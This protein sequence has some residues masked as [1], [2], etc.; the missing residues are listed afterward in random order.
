MAE[1]SDDPHNNGGQENIGAVDFFYYPETKNDLTENVKSNRNSGNNGHADQQG[2]AGST[3]PR[4][5]KI[6]QAKSNEAETKDSNHGDDNNRHEKGIQENG[7]KNITSSAPKEKLPEKD[8]F[9]NIK[10][11]ITH[12][13]SNQT[14]EERRTVAGFDYTSQSYSSV[15]TA[16]IT[17]VQPLTKQVKT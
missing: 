3:K 13:E 6:N 2:N 16:N 14:S 7:E 15:V 5:E 8:E 1:H 12:E 4:K 11:P 17:Q 10:Q 9:V